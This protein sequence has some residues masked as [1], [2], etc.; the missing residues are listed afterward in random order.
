ML[1]SQGCSIYAPLTIGYATN[2]LTRHDSSEAVKYIVLYVGLNYAVQQLTE[3]QNCVYQEVRSNAYRSIA[4]KIF[5]HLLS[6]SI[7]WHLKKRMGVALRVIDRG[8]TSADNVVKYLV[9]RILPTFIGV[10]VLR[11]V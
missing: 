2:A 1:T 5:D 11:F 6:L 4:T 9:L 10:G 7:D 3:L 8:Q